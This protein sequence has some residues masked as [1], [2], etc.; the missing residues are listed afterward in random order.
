MV[1]ISELKYNR[2]FCCIILDNGESYWLR[3]TDL[4]GS[5]FLCGEQYDREQILNYIRICQYPRAL[6]HSVSLLARRPYSKNEIYTHL[7]RLRYASE[8]ADLVLF[9]LEKEN[10]VNDEDFCEQWIRFRS[11]HHYGQS[12]IRRE[13]KIKGIPDEV[14]RRSLNRISPE[15]SEAGAFALAQKS[16]QKYVSEK[17]IYKKRQKV[18]AFLIRKGYS[19]D[20]ARAACEKAE[21]EPE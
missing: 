19:W 10:L 4:S 11:G 15:E 2:S 9:K 12:F 5:G 1:T 21:S 16:W 13:L 18:I 6:N 8:I 3:K 20:D 7:I 17:N 14:I